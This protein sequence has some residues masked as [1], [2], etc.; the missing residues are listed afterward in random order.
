MRWKRETKRREATDWSAGR[1]CIAKGTTEADK[2]I[3]CRTWH[4]HKRKSFVHTTERLGQGQRTWSRW[5]YEDTPGAAIILAPTPICLVQAVLWTR[6]T[7]IPKWGILWKILGEKK[8][9]RPLN[10]KNDVPAETP[11]REIPKTAQ[12]SK[13][14]YNGEDGRAPG[15]S[16]FAISALLLLRK[17]AQRGTPEA[18]EKYLIIF[19]DR[20]DH[21]SLCNICHKKLTRRIKGT[22]PPE[23]LFTKPARKDGGICQ[24]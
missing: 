2:G 21:A 15:T 7:I 8:V 14:S 18:P 17:P 3:R 23:A 16:T 5:K 10:I 20:N 1:A 9:G 6:S 13:T 19:F 11:G 12:F 24:A 22:I 4:E